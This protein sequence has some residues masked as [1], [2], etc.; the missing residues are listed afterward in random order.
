MQHPLNRAGISS[1]PTAEFRFKRFKYSE[2]RFKR[3]K[4]LRVSWSVTFL[5]VNWC[6]S[7]FTLIFLGFQ[8]KS[9]SGKAFFFSELAIVVKNLQNP[10]VISSL[11]HEVTPLISKVFGNFSAF[12]LIG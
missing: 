6:F 9:V 5:N 3:F 2:F 8:T 11:L 4:Y 12:D 7:K 1:K 10:F